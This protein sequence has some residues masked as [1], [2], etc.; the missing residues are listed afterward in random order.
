MYNISTVSNVSVK[1][2]NKIALKRKKKA[3]NSLDQD[4]LQLLAMTSKAV[5]PLLYFS[6]V[7]RFG[8]FIFCLIR[9][10]RWPCHQAHLHIQA[11]VVQFLSQIISSTNNF[12]DTQGC[13]GNS[14]SKYLIYLAPYLFVTFCFFLHF[15]GISTCR[16]MNLQKASNFSWLF[17][18]TAIIIISHLK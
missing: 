3:N 9:N 1:V 15:A 16:V 8:Y 2:V 11:N 17:K 7:T 12:C 6:L 18:P 14:H 10:N 13:N 4:N 5:W